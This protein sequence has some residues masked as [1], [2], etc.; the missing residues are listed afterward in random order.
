ML[1]FMA[2]KTNKIH[3]ITLFVGAVM[4]L[5]IAFLYLHDVPTQIT[6]D[7]EKYITLILTEAGYS[8]ENLSQQASGDFKNQISAIKNIQAS[9]FSTAPLTKPLP[10]N[11]PKEPKNLYEAGFGNC[12]D[13]SRYLDKAL[14]MA[15]FN[16]RYASIY[17]TP[18]QTPAWRAVLSKSKTARSHA[19]VEVQTKQ[20]WVFVD[21]VTPWMAIS[22]QGKPVSLEEWKEEKDNIEWSQQV[23]AEIYPVLEGDFVHIYGLYSRHGRFYPPYNF[24]PDI[25][26]HS[27]LFHNF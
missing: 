24:F 5:V 10:L 13:R 17:E 2:L 3:K 15:G 26:W 19:L 14:R 21:S 9:V 1:V 6:K 4:L 20:G 25:D 27:L 7:D 22:A 16:T 11:T 23:E 12:N 18:D 8:P